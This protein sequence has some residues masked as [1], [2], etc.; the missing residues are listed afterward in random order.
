MKFNYINAVKLQDPTFLENACIIVD[1]IV[2]KFVWD[3]ESKQKNQIVS[4]I[5]FS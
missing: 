4:G 2:T 5:L 1:Q 3:L